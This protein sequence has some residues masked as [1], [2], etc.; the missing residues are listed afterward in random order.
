MFWIQQIPAKPMPAP[1][2]S[3]GMTL[4]ELSSTGRVGCAR[5]Y[6]YYRDI[7]RPYLTKLSNGS[8][9]TGGVPASAGAELS[10]KRRLQGLED[11]LR[12]A[13]AGQRFEDCASL[14]DEIARLKE[15]SGR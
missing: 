9:H 14:R 15:E 5:C 3:C 13:V 6:E 12:R 8:A 7:L 2:P 1:C 4:R 11:E 10:A